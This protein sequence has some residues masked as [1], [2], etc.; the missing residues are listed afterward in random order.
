ML[1]VCEIKITVVP[2]CY[3]CEIKIA[4]VPSCY[5]CEITITLMSSCYVCEI[6]IKVVPSCCVS[7]R[8]RVS[9]YYNGKFMDGCPVDVC[10]PSQVRVREL[11][12]GHVG[13]Q[14][15]FHGNVVIS[16]VLG[17]LLPLLLS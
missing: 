7:G 4:V 16:L 6:T 8:W 12:G 14:Q 9:M 5:V 2:S 17:L 10:D 3:E 13:K 1:C 15:T 11:R